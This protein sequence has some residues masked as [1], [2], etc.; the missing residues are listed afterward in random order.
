MTYA[1]IIKKI[2][3]GEERGTEGA[4]TRALGVPQG[5]P[6]GSHFYAGLPCQVKG[7]DRYT[8]LSSELSIVH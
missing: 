1:I 6:G 7:I 2:D 5:S 4:G 8:F 3:F